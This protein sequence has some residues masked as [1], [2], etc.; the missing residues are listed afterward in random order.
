MSISRR[1]SSAAFV[2][3]ALAGSSPSLAA[4]GWY[5]RVPPRNDRN[6]LE[7]LDTEPLSKWTQQGAYD[8]AS[9]CEAVRNA[10]ST[11]EYKS[12]SDAQR[13]YGLALSG[14]KDPA[15]L[16]VIQSALENYRSN[17]DGLAASRCT[18]SDDPRLGK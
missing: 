17:Y 11:V 6:V 16:A 18:K 8:S 12:Y 13:R 14:K 2:L 15:E 5:L 1:A 9:E 10:L 4:G 7:V 3:V